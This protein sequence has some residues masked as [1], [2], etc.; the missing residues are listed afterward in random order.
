MVEA[1]VAMKECTPAGYT[2]REQIRG[3]RGGGVAVIHRKSLRITEY[4]PVAATTFEY[5][6]YMIRT[7]RNNF[8][9]TNIYRPTNV[10]NNTAANRQLFL[11]EFAALVDAIPI[12]SAPRIFTGDFNIHVNDSGCHV[13]TSFLELL[14]T[15]DM[16]QH[17][18]GST[19]TSGNT[20]DLV[21]TS[22]DITPVCSISPGVSD[23]EIVNFA[24]P[25]HVLDAS[26]YKTIKYRR[27]RAINVEDFRRDVA[28]LQLQQDR[29]NSAITMESTLE[30]FYQQM[31]DLADLHAPEITKRVRDKPGSEWFDAECQQMKTSVRRLEEVMRGSRQD[32][33]RLQNRRL[34]LRGKRE[35]QKLCQDKQ[36]ELWRVRLNNNNTTNKWPIINQMLFKAKSQPDTSCSA[37]DFASHFSTKITNIRSHLTGDADQPADEPDIDNVQQYLSEFTNVTRIDVETILKSRPNKQCSLDPTP[38]T[39]VKDCN[40]LLS[41]F[42]TTIINSSLEIGVMP[43]LEKRSL[44]TPLLKKYNLDANDMGNYRPIS[45]LSIISKLIECC[46]SRQLRR[47]F[48]IVPLPVSQSAYRPFHSTETALLGFLNDVRCNMSRGLATATVCLDMS[49]AFDTVD[50]DILLRRMQADFRVTGTCLQWFRSYLSCRSQ[51]VVVGESSSED[52][53]CPYGVP[54]GSVLGPTLFSMYTAPLHDII[55]DHGCSVVMYADDIAIHISFD[56]NNSRDQLHRLQR[57]IDD[58]ST[59]LRKNMLKLNGDKTELIIFARNNN[60]DTLAPLVDGL[61]NVDG[62]TLIPS[63]SIK[64]L[65]VTLDNNLTLKPHIAQTSRISTW[66]LREIRRI[67][68]RLDRA[69]M[70]IIVRS[71]VMSR[72]DYCNAIYLQL[73]QTTIQPLVRVLHAAART[74]SGTRLYD[75]ITPVLTDLHWLPLQQ[76]IMYKVAC[77]IF[78]CLQGTSAPYIAEHVHMLDSERLMAARL[79]KVPRRQCYNFTCRAPVVWNNL[80]ATLRSP[81]LSLSA[82]LKQLKTFLFTEAYGR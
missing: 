44:V 12:N 55:T 14:F 71:F 58:V 82:F 33:V 11:T 42:F 26:S 38:M 9:A 13:A 36:N 62:H 67:R 57:A 31:T 69:T 4:R 8:V 27:W 78:R 56:H 15:L 61:V 59:W 79:L 16:E 5:G 52:T 2:H 37:T 20:L 30:S 46:V 34:Y 72:V 75:H 70:E 74:I 68:A 50:H 23:H 29:H 28:A 60:M 63:D 77:I 24:L 35:Y 81:E 19:H 53:P 6:C 7:T 17:V 10:N 3:S 25:M 43:S 48:N 54:Q 47:H 73:P 64:Y 41:P 49:A 40:D 45:N 32:D 21:V 22:S 18:R 65:G 39:I 1:S 76:R 66:Q 80:P 51:R